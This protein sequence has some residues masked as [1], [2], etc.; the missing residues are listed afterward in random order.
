MRNNVVAKGYVE[1]E[2]V[3]FAIT[4]GFV[5]PSEQQNLTLSK[6]YTLS[7]PQ[8]IATNEQALTIPLYSQQTKA[9]FFSLCYSKE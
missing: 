6:E 7:T 2:E 3:A 9:L 5:S 1:E 4:D 8:C